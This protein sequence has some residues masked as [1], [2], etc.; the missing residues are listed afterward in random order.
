MNQTERCTIHL[1]DASDLKRAVDDPALAG[2]FA[3]GWRNVAAFA[4]EQ[5]QG[6]E[7]VALILAPP[8]KTNAR[9]LKASVAIL[10]TLQV[11]QILAEVLS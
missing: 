5:T 11:V 1:L 9:W 10:I 3:T 8:E 7:Q 6:S 2:L 4:V